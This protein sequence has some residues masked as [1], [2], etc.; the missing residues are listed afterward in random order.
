MAVSISNLTSIWSNSSVIYTGLGLNVNAQSYDANSSVVKFDLNN[1]YLLKL[2]SNGNLYLS[3]NVFTNGTALVVSSDDLAISAFTKAN[4]ANIVAVSAFNKANNSLANTTGTIFGGV[5]YITSNLGIGLTS[6]PAANLHVVGDII[7]T[8]DITSSYSDERLKDILSP[9]ENALD[10]IETIDTF[11]YR[12]NQI[13]LDLGMK[14]EEQVGVS[15]QQMQKILPQI[16][17]CAPV[18][19]GYYTI[20]Y[21]RVV[22][23]LIQAIKELK[24]EIEELKNVKKL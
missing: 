2:S 15:A 12:P 14:N 1:N 19:K 17:K 22:P 6:S 9:I 21:E 5:M 10:K 20:Q 13:A 11:F 3:G 8:G 24:K 18:G 4:S 16:I 23:L 7:A